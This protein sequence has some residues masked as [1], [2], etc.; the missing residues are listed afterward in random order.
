M[1]Y[2]LI[3]F[4]LTLKNYVIFLILSSNLKIGNSFLKK[5]FFIAISQITKISQVRYITFRL[6][7]NNNSTLKKKKS[8]IYHTT[9]RYQNNSKQNISM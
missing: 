5:L 3:F 8:K 4:R 7:N 1:G 6:S 2:H 9:K